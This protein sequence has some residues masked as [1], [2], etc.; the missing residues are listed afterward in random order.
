MVRRAVSLPSFL[1]YF[2]KHKQARAHTVFLTRSSHSAL[3]IQGA[4]PKATSQKYLL[5]FR[6]PPDVHRKAVI[7]ISVG[8]RGTSSEVDMGWVHRCI[9]GLGRVGWVFFTFWWVWFGSVGSNRSKRAYLYT[10]RIIIIT[11]L[12]FLD[13]NEKN[14]ILVLLIMFSIIDIS[15]TGNVFILLS[16]FL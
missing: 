5:K 12:R 8:Y 15:R 4:W 7:S 13:S 3:S 6:R 2:W 11:K 16:F 14:Y 1:C 9:R 10:D